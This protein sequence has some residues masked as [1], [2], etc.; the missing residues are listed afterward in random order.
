MTI[1]DVIKLMKYVGKY[2]L[3]CILTHLNVALKFA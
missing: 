3:K 2:D 1:Y